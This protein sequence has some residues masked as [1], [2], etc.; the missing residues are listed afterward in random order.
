M[1]R[2]IVRENGTRK[3]VDKTYIREHPGSVTIICEAA[4][5]ATIKQNI[6][7]WQQRSAERHVQHDGFNPIA[8]HWK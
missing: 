3:V 5:D 4:D 7:A 2:Y 8:I 6:H 1:K